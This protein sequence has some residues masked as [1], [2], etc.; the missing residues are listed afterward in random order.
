MAAARD[1]N[2]MLMAAMP[3]GMSAADTI[4]LVHEYYSSQN[5]RCRSWVMNP[6]AD[7]SQTEPLKLALLN[8]GLQTHAEDVLYLQHVAS[9]PIVPSH[10]LT[11][12]PARASFRHAR[13]LAEETVV[14]R[15]PEE[16]RQL[17]EAAIAHLDDPH[18]DALLALRD[19]RAIAKVGVLAAGE[20]GRIEPL[21]VAEAHRRQGVGRTMMAR[22]LEICARSLFKHVFLSCNTDNEPAQQLYRSLGFVRIGQMISYDARP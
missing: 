22:A 1:A 14:G 12:I 20:I 21:F 16:A 9:A 3:E 18:Y 7:Q 4:T 17:V 5:A 13:E 11:I 8:Q 15:P 19:G 10:D 2:R 6:S